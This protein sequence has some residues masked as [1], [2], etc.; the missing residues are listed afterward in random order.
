MRQ[1]K[2]S[3]AGPP[4]WPSAAPSCS[5]SAGP[6][7]LRPAPGRQGLQRHPRHRGHAPGRQDRLLRQSLRPDPGHGRLRRPGHPLRELHRP[8]APDP[9][10]AHDHHD[11]HAAALPRRPRQRRLRRPAGARDHGRDVQ[12]QGLRHGGLRRRLRPRLQ[13]GPEP[14]LRHVLRQVRPEPLREDL[15]RRGPAA[16][17]RGHRRGPGLARAEKGRQVLRLDPPLRP[18]HALRAAGAVQERV[19]PKPLPRR[20]RLHRLPARPALGLPRPATGSATTSSSSS[21]PT[22]AKAW[23]STRRDHTASSSTRPPSTCP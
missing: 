19:S 11:R 20:D 4:S 8:D 14:G 15:A 3:I 5:C 1:E 13:V 9:A 2:P 17:Q 6:G 7:R 10:L 23:A 22:T 18:A 16:G 21:P 12:G